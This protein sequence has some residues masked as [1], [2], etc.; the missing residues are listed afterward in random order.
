MRYGVFVLYTGIFAYHAYCYDDVSIIVTI[1]VVH[2]TYAWSTRISTL[3]FV[4][5]EWRENEHVCTP[6]LS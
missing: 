1:C 5:N 4:L 2:E 6:F 3:A